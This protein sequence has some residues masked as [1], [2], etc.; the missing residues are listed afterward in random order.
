VWAGYETLAETSIEGI[1]P[2]N[3]EPMTEIEPAYSAWE[4]DSVLERVID[5]AW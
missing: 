2:V 1:C 4:A 3:V 5:N